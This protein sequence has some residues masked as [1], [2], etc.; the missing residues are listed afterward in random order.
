MFDCAVSSG[1]PLSK[2][3]LSAA[4]KD[5]FAVDNDLKKAFDQFLHDSTEVP[6]SL[7]DWALPYLVWRWQVRQTYQNTEQIQK[8]NTEDRGLLWDANQYFCLSDEQIKNSRAYAEISSQQTRSFS[9]SDTQVGL[10]HLEMEAPALRARI[11]ALPKISPTLAEFF[12]K[13]VHDSVAG[14]RKQFVEASGHWRYR[15]VFRGSA[16]PYIG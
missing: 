14:F 8:A 2:G 4:D 13:F 3:L 16:T 11:A 10:L 15:R 9:R 1:V 6:R 12:D 5:M 7:G